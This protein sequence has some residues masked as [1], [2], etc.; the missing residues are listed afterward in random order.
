MNS[1]RIVS[2][3]IAAMN[4][5]LFAGLFL[6]YSNDQNLLNSLAPYSYIIAI[7]AIVGMVTCILNRKI[8]MNFLASGTIIAQFGGI[9]ITILQ[10]GY[11]LSG[12]KIGFYV[13][14]VVGVI[15]L[16][17]TIVYS[18]MASGASQRGSGKLTTTTVNGGTP[19][20]GGLVQQTNS[21]N[22]NMPVNNFKSLPVQLAEKEKAP[23][24]MLLGGAP[25]GVA[26]PQL[27]PN[28]VQS[29]MS[30][31]GLQSINISQD[32]P[33]GVVQNQMIPPQAL[34]APAPQIQPFPTNIVQAPPVNQAQAGPRPDLLAGSGMSGQ[35]DNSPYNPNPPQG[36]GQFL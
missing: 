35:L 18:I 20:N 32:N 1:K 21:L 34:N 16:I 25:Q 12:L 36:P 22:M 15:L 9:L 33:S 11:D 30:E 14:L 3:A 31:L 19:T 26:A 2:I 5:I 8:E 6:P 23:M 29:H 28:T 24:D 13:Y 27:Q 17:L 10:N 7:Y 4:A